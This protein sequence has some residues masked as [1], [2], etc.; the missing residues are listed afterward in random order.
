MNIYMYPKKGM[1]TYPT[2]REVFGKSSTQICRIFEGICI[3][4]LEGIYMYGN[5]GYIYID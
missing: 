3:H 2:K 4:S 1:D 5:I